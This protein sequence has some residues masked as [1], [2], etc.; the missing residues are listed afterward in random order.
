MVCGTGCLSI[1]VKTLISK[2]LKKLLRGKINDG[3]G[4]IQQF[5][6]NTVRQ[7]CLAHAGITVKEQIG[8]SLVKVTDK[9]VADLCYSMNTFQG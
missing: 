1:P 8:K 3:M 2:S 7:E 4:G 5:F 9:P 6:G